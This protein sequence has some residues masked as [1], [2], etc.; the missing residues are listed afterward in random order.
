MPVFEQSIQIPAP[1]ERVDRC[2]TE[3]DLMRQWLNPMLKCE[4][5]GSWSVAEGS[6]FRFIVQIPWLK[7]TLDCVVTERRQGLVVWS[8]TGFF[9]GSDR[10]EC[11][12]EG[13]GTLLVNRFTFQ[14]PNPLIS[15]GFNLT[16]AALTRQDMQKQLQ[17]L[18]KV[19]TTLTS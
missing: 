7:P 2:V 4:S 13:K 8:F 5:I 1:P 17:R 19:A 6:R 18:R 3:P 15:L 16:A 14:I 11:R 10:W 12:S 9:T